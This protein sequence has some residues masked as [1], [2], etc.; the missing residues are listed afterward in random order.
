MDPFNPDTWKQQWAVLMT[1]PYIIAPLMLIAGCIRLV[2][3]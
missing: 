3:S 1:A 2:V